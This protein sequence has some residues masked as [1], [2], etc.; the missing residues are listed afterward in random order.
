MKRDFQS[1]LIDIALVLVFILVQLYRWMCGKPGYVYVMYDP[2]S[3][4]TKIGYSNSPEL[5]LKELKVYIPELKLIKSYR[6]MTEASARHFEKKLHKK[7][8]RQ[9]KNHVVQC[10]GRTE[11]FAIKSKTVVDA[12]ERMLDE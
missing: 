9:R 2:A 4:L 8:A 11:F 7:Y 6:F 3:Q 1:W 10:A 5:R 12:I